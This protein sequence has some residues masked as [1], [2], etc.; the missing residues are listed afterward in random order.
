MKKTWQKQ[1]PM[2]EV[3]Y[4]NNKGHVITKYRKK[5]WVDTKKI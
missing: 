5:K 3:H 4:C 1:R 2:I